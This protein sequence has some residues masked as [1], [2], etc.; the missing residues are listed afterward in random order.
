MTHYVIICGIRPFIRLQLYGADW[1]SE[2]QFERSDSSGWVYYQQ[3]QILVLKL[4]HRTAVE[5]VRL[6]YREAPPPPPPPP[7]VEDS[8][9]EEA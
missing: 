2:A 7:V 4:R 6:I 3:S 9:G 8:G 1:R 5:N